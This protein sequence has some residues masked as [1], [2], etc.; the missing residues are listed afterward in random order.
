MCNP[1]DRLMLMRTNQAGYRQTARVELAGGLA[2]AQ[3]QRRQRAARLHL[4][5]QRASCDNRRRA[6][7][8]HLMVAAV[9]HSDEVLGHTVGESL[10]PAARG[11]S[12]GFL[13]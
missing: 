4:A 9:K 5:L 13:L 7:G 8:G 1:S 11:I 3:R 2:R 10:C 12:T 6:R